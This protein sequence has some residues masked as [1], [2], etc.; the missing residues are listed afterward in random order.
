[1]IVVDASVIVEILLVTPAAGRIATHLFAAGET[2]HAPR[3][4]DVDVAQAC[5]GSRSPKS[6]IRRVLQRL[7]KTS[8]RFE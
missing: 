7:S 3:L 5:A 6:S 4:S 2:L 1:M 8:Q